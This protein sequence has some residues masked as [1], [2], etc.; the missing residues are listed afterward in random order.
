[1]YKFQAMYYSYANIAHALDMPNNQS[2]IPALIQ[3]FDELLDLTLLTETT[4]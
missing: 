4:K 2:Y 1:M 3:E